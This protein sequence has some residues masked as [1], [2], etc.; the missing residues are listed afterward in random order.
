MFRIPMNY[1][2]TG[3][4]VELR[5]LVENGIDIWG[6]V[7][8][9]YYTG[10]EK[11]AFEKKVIDHYYFRQIG[12][13]TPGRW[14]HYFRNRILEIMPYY[15]QLYKSVE[16]MMN[17]EDPFKAYDLTEEYTEQRADTGK[18][19]GTSGTSGTDTRTSETERAGT[20]TSDTDAHR[21]HTT[22]TDETGTDTDTRKYSDTPQGEVDLIDNY[23][24]DYTK[25][26]KSIA[27][28]GSVTDSETTGEDVN[29][30]T[31]ETGSETASATS[32]TSGT[33]E[34]ETE[35]TGNTT[36]TLK[37][38]GNIGVQP[39]GQEIEAYRKA[40]INVDLMVINELKDL[41]LMVY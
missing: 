15:V 9:S 24:T 6:F 14:L 36:Y 27:R 18:T 26:S 35:S 38:Y 21:Q 32:E 20:R 17:V 28:F 31:S 22:N 29:E 4:T 25:T 8:P 34:T 30:T 41:F 40:L 33:S 13:E 3:V 10:D 16:L 11:K 39:L 37:R 7:Y 1:D 19:S 23:L 12:Q 5:E 2:N